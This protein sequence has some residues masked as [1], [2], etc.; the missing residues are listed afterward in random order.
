M[1]RCTGWLAAL[2]CLAVL[3][4]AVSAEER[5]YTEDGQ[6]KVR[7]APVAEEF[8]NTP[9]PAEMEKGFWERA[10]HAMDAFTQP[11]KTAT[12]GEHEKWNYPTLMFNYLNSL[13]KPAEWGSLGEH[14]VK[15]LQVEDAQANTDHKYT[16]GIDWYW[17]FTIKGQI[18]KYFYFGDLLDPAYRER[19]TEG[20][21]AWTADDPRPSM[22]LILSMDSEDPMVREHATRLMR[23]M[24][25]SKDELLKFAEQDAQSEHEIQH[26]FAEHARKLARDWPT[27]DEL[28]TDVDAWE[29]WWKGL[30][31][32]GWEVFEEYERLA[33]PR[34]HPVYD[35]GTG[36]VGGAW[37]PE[38]RGMWADA[39]NTDNLRAMRETTAYLM[40]EQTGNETIRRLYKDKI[41]RFVSD[42]YRVGMGEWDSENYLAHTTVPYL[43]LYDFAED[44]EV[45]K[46]AKAGLDWLTM[47][48][49]LKYYRGG[50]GGPS[51]RDYGGARR[52][53]GSGLSHLM[54]LYFG[55]TPVEDPSPHYDD[56]HAITSSYRPPMA[57]AGIA[58]KDFDKPV[59]MFNAKPAYSLWLPGA[60]DSPQFYETMF[61]GDSYYLGTLTS[62][63]TAGDVGA[64]KMMA[65]NSQ[66]GADY[67]LANSGGKITGKFAGDQIGQFRNMAIWLRESPKPFIFQI[68]GN[69]EVRKTDRMWLIGMEKTFVAV[70]PIGLEDDPDIQPNPETEFVTFSADATADRPTGFAMLVGEKP[71]FGSLDE[72]AQALSSQ[73]TLRVTGDRADLTGLD[74]QRLRVVLNEQSN[75]PFV[76]RDGEQHKWTDHY[77]LYGSPDGNS[78]IVQQWKGNGT[79]EIH[80]GGYEFT[81]TVT[82]DGEV[83][84]SE[85][86]VD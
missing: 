64:F 63:G 29:A 66:R 10:N 80:A 34:P 31:D 59:E 52:I 75:L 82:T 84:W 9:W 48:G 43:N 40:A 74:G 58:R 24:L 37:Q 41:R 5:V 2:L 6:T 55:D 30:S 54:Y 23:E 77:G 47:A 11:A 16:E 8:R 73:A 72:F 7:Q 71:Q 69:A 67:F 57:V 27:A 39:R 42:L 62:E 12:T 79:L 46:L 36:P 13:R 60:T 76:F 44:P 53:F 14:A 17:C 4:P 85:K 50:I 32:A 86:K 3:T 18:R 65:Y 61:F 78:P 68:P 22:E 38:V 28:G 21:K 45:K 25:V 81:Q 26:V 19:M 56:V 51:K 15:G 70:W 35:V 49:A 20:A 33:N 1:R 83:T